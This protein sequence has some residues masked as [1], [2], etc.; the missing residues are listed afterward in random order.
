[1]QQERLTNGK[2]FQ[3][4]LSSFK[5]PIDKW[6]KNGT[7]TMGH[8]FCEL[9]NGES[10][11]REENGDLIRYVRGVAVNVYYNRQGSLLKLVEDRQEFVNGTSRHRNLTSSFGEKMLPDETA[12]ETAVRG[13]SEELGVSGYE[14]I[15]PMIEDREPKI[16]ETY[17]GLMTKHYIQ[18]FDVFLRPEDYK[19]EGYVE[20]QHDKSTFFVWKEYPIPAN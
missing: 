14:F 5:I 1:M 19:P 3:A 9:R 8:L 7:K 20:I 10:E 18:V 17:P 16:S 11:L 4:Y 13:L 15:N 12:L 6:G 2:T